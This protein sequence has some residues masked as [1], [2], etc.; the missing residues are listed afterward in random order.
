ML[1]QV[2][3]TA[4]QSRDICAAGCGTECGTCATPE[5]TAVCS[6]CC[7]AASPLS[8]SCPS[9]D[10]LTPAT[11]GLLVATIVGWGLLL[12]V[13]VIVGQGWIAGRSTPPAAAGASTVS[14]VSAAATDVKLERA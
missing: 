6:V 8:P 11:I 7:P 10:G 13:G 4:L 9:S 1:A 2:L 12:L 3:N 5:C 14:N